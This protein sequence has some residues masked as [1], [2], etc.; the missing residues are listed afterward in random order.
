MESNE[1][2]P[3]IQDRLRKHVGIHWNILE[4]A[5]RFGM[6]P[7]TLLT[8]LTNPPMKGGENQIRVWH[9]LAAVGYESPEQRQLPRVPLADIGL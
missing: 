7:T 1:L 4:L 8:W 3:L 9:Y 5:E 2:W 6:S